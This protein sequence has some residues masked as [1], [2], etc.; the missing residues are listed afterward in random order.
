M[1]NSYENGGL[2][3]LDFRTLVKS[4]RLSWLKRLFTSENAGWKCYLTHLLKPFGGL[5]HLHCDYDPKDYNISN[6][7]YA[8]LIHF[9]AEFRNAFSDKDNKK[10][11]I[12]NNKNLRIDG[13]PVF[14]KKFFE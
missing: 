5:F 8:D 1:I 4:V 13:K 14:Y 6:Q 2:R 3:M 12:W 10:S 11:T 9:W 7:F